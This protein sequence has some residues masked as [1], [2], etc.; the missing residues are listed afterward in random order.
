MRN[1][2]VSAFYPGLP[3]VSND[4]T[5]YKDM[6]L[7]VDE[8]KGAEVRKAAP[9]K[10]HEIVW[11]EFEKTAKKAMILDVFTEW[12]RMRQYYIPKYRVA[13]ETKDGKW[14]EKFQYVFPGN[15]YRGYLAMKAVPEKVIV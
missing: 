2:K 10:P 3:P 12:L 14:S 1:F 11:I 4:V 5:P 15:V 6:S 8:S 13:V 7:E 9:F